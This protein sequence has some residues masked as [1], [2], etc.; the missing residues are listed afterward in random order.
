MKR[1]P[2]EILCLLL[3][4]ISTMDTSK[5]LVFADMGTLTL[6]PIGK[7][8][9][10]D[11]FTL[12]FSLTENPEPS[13]FFLHP[14]GDLL[15]DHQLWDNI[16]PASPLHTVLAEQATDHYGEKG[17]LICCPYTP[18]KVPRNNPRPVPDTQEVE[19]IIPRP[20]TP[21]GD[22]QR[23]IRFPTAAHR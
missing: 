18:L 23:T 16:Q 12:S 1:P 15:K 8:H 19:L 9:L 20:V 11:T 13:P 21:L 4:Y 17:A 3:V 10:P 5:L 6:P 7:K 22:T 2:I 14:K